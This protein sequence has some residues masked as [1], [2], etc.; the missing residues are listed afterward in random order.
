MKPHPLE[1]I[2]IV[3]YTLQYCSLQYWSVHGVEL[4]VS[5]C[6]L[7]PC[8]S[9]AWWEKHS[10][11]PLTALKKRLCWRYL[12]LAVTPTECSTSSANSPACYPIVLLPGMAGRVVFAEL[13]WSPEKQSPCDSL[14]VITYGGLPG[15]TL[16]H[17]ASTDAS[18]CCAALV[19]PCG[20]V[21][22]FARNLLL[23]NFY[24]QLVLVFISPRCTV[25]L[26][27]CLSH[28]VQPDFNRTPSQTSDSAAHRE[29]FLSV[30]INLHW[31]IRNQWYHYHF[32]RRQKEEGK[33]RDGMEGCREGGRGERSSL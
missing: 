20:D 24:F 2:Y 31:P 12:F 5:R 14:S 10:L 26:C 23:S 3:Q 8:Y 32:K 16:S 22:H 15:M 13:T 33:G 7:C 4:S 18:N 25:N 1:F 21:C 28:S 29:R 9:S 19:C 11:W 30:T 6:F 27:L 17:T